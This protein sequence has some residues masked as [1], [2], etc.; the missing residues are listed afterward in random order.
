MS[1]ELKEKVELHHVLLLGNP[2][3]MKE[4]PGIV[5]E[6]MRTNEILTELR[7]VVVRINWL[8]ISGFIVALGA[9]VIKGFT[10]A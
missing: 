5:S 1:D 4:Q 10:A 2:H 8:L 6:Q 9:L 3:N 7:G